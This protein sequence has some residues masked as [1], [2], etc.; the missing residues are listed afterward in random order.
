MN[1]FSSDQIIWVITY[2][3]DLIGNRWPLEPGSCYFDAGSASG[4]TSA[5][6]SF[7][8]ASL[9]RAELD[10]RLDLTGLDGEKLLQEIVASETWFS[11]HSWSVILYCKGRKRKRHSYSQWKAD[12]KYR[13]KMRMA[14][15]KGPPS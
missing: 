2:A 7:E 12:R 13:D 9:V 11:D 1:Q 15:V 4:Y 5:H 10:A 6:G 14:P 3:A 8:T